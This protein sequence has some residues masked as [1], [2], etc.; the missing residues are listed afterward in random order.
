MNRAIK[1][2]QYSDMKQFTAPD[3]VQVIPVDKNTWLPADDTC[4]EDYSLAFLDG[5][6]P[7]STCSHMGTAPQTLIQGLTSSGTVN[8]ATTPETPQS[9]PSTDT[10]EPK[11]KN[12]L[13]KIF[14][15]GDKPAPP[16]TPAPPPQ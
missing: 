12:F 3:G 13:Q 2:P 10:T 1:L 5:T 4:P 8:P 15:G 6:V 14:G 11:K 16:Q 7:A 9:P